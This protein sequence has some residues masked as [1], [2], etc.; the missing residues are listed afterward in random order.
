MPGLRTYVKGQRVTLEVMVVDA[1]DLG[2]IVVSF[3]GKL[4]TAIPLVAL[5]AAD[6]N[7]ER[8]LTPE[9]VDRA[10]MDRVE[11]ETANASRVSRREQREK[12]EAARK[13]IED[14]AEA[15]RVAAAAQHGKK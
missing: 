10:E 14:D 3:G 7:P 2:N 11:T 12:E 6:T 13:K 4:D 1:H 15:A 8:P 9:E 5:D